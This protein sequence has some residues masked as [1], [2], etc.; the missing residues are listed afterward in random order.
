LS[1]AGQRRVSAGQ[2]TLID[3]PE[4]QHRTWREVNPMTTT[5]D[6][7]AGRFHGV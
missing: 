7:K 2:Q 5:T 3:K 6:I 4:Q 1:A